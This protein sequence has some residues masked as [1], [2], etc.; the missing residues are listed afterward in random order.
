[1]SKTILSITIPTYNRSHDLRACLESIARQVREDS[2]LNEEIEVVVSD[3]CSTDDTQE[4]AGSFSGAFSNFVYSRNETNV[5]FDKNTY[6][7][8]SRATSTYCWYLGDDDVIQNGGLRH[9][10]DTLKTDAYDVMTVEA[11]PTKGDSRDKTRESYAQ[12]D[13]IRVVDGNE[14]YFKGYC[15]GGFSVLIFNREMWMSVVDTADY[16]THWLYYETILKML[17]A[18]TKPMLYVKKPIIITGQDCRWAENGT[19]LF[20]YVNSNLLMEKMISFGF[21]KDRLSSELTANSQKIVIMV[22]RA[23]GHGLRYTYANLKYIYRNLRYA[24]RWRLVVATAVYF[25]P[26][27]IVAFVRDVRKRLA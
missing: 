25:V 12:Q 10:V 1:M 2:A 5:G 24:K 4:V 18:T 27:G 9:V 22:L 7:V 16:L 13:E 15:Q 23:K 19:E 26:N 8:V 11:S 3:N 20:T 6:A 21:D 14:F 17:I